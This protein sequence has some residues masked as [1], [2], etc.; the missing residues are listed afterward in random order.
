V[1]E[2][3]PK[4]SR[5]SEKSLVNTA[6]RLRTMFF[7]SNITRTVMA[8]AGSRHATRVEAMKVKRR[9]IAPE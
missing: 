3:D 6:I 9:I 1:F 2:R 5:L 8:M 7:E 4:R